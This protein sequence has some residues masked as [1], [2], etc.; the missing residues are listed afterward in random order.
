M[1]L[2]CL[3]LT[4]PGGLV[5]NEAVNFR[6]SIVTTEMVGSAPDLV[7]D[8][9]NGFIYPVGDIEKLASCFSKPLQELN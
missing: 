8:G 3:Q 6:F 1:Y 5:I 9:E 7:K 2:F 4:N